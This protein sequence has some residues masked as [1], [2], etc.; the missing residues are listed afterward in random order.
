[1]E[2]KINFKA[3]SGISLSKRS[4]ECEFSDVKLLDYLRDES[5]LNHLEQ[6]F[7]FRIGKSDIRIPV[8]KHL[9][10]RIIKSCILLFLLLL[11]L[12]LLIT[13]LLRQ[14]INNI[15]YNILL[16]QYNNIIVILF[17]CY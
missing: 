8:E 16:R 10:T 7:S 2:E 6:L 13:I 5:K 17:Y 1:M 3:W 11:L 14:Y 15:L 4:K 12:L 9:Q